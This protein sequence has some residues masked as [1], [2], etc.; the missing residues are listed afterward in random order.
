MI[1]TAHIAL[2]NDSIAA[3]LDVCA[4]DVRSHISAGLECYGSFIF[5]F[6]ILHFP[7]LHFPVPRFPILY[8]QFLYSVPRTLKCRT[9]TDLTH[10]LPKTWCKTERAPM[11]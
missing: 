4:F 5:V 2:E 6:Q 11:N 10:Y 7:V 8:F 3:T 1:N 9:S